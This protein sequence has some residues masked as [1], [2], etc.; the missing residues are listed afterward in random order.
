MLCL[1]SRSAGFLGSLCDSL[2]N[3]HSV[4]QDSFEAASNGL[5]Q[6]L[7]TL[8]AFEWSLQLQSKSAGFLGSLRDSHRVVQDSC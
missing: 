2:F 7:G 1:H 3:S 4:V 6:A 8:S 5:I